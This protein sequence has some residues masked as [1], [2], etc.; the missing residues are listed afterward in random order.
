MGTATPWDFIAELQNPGRD[1]IAPSDQQQDRQTRRDDQER[2]D[3]P[4][5]DGEPRHAIEIADA[6]RSAFD[7][8]LSR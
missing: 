4:A 6:N 3:R 7:I 2:T 5:L 8:R 1:D